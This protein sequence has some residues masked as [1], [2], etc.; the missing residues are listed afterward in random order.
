MLAIDN[1]KMKL[2]IYHLHRYIKIKYPV[3]IFTKDV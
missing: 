2:K 3:S 1:W